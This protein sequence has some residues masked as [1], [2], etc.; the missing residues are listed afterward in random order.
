M[1]INIKECIIW[2]VKDTNKNMIKIEK[3]SDVPKKYEKKKIRL[4]LDYEED[5]IF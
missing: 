3:I 1:A 2:E 5:F 4:T